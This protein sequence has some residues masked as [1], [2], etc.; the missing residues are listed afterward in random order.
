MLHTITEQY[1]LKTVL[2]NFKEQDEKVLKELTQLHILE[3]FSSVYST[4]LTK[5]QR[6]EVVSSKM[7]LKENCNG[8]IKVHACA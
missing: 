2:R 4:K 3:T 7:F 8:Q 6:E 5:K 1:S